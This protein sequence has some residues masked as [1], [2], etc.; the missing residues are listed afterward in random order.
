M[1][2]TP[3]RLDLPA[4]RCRNARRIAALPQLIGACAEAAS[5]VYQPIAAARPARKP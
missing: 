5:T 1:T 4:R 2:T 3:D